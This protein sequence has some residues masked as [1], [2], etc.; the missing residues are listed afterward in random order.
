MHC[1]EGANLK[2]QTERFYLLS[3]VLTKTLLFSQS[4]KIQPPPYPVVAPPPP[5]HICLLWGHFY[6]GSSSPYASTLCPAKKKDV[7]AAIAAGGLQPR[8]DVV[9]SIFEG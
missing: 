3:R 8:T 1:F 5:F 4:L 7:N 2:K 9:L 6:V